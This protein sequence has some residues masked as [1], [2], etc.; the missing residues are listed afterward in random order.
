LI[1]ITTTPWIML[2]TIS[3]GFIPRHTALRL[4]YRI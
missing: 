3:T 1:F 4:I 2:I